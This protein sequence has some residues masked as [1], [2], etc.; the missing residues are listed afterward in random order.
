MTTY[1]CLFLR[2]IGFCSIAAAYGRTID[3][4]LPKNKLS[5]LPWIDEYCKYMSLP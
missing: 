2:M 1:Y 5:S 4:F 3:F